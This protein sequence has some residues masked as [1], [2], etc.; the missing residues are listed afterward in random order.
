MMSELKMKIPRKIQ[1]IN[2]ETLK[3]IFKNMRTQLDF[4]VGERGRQFEHLMSKQ[5]VT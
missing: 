2:Q 1:T 5:C 4:V 3:N